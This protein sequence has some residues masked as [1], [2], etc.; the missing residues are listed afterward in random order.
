MAVDQIRDAVNKLSET[1]AGAPGGAG[2]DTTATATLRDGLAF[3]VSGPRGKVQT[4]M[5]AAIGGAAAG[6]PPAWLLRAALASCT[7]SVI[8]MRAASLGVKLDTLEVS[9]DSE[10]NI[11]GMLG[12]DEKISAGLGALRMQ[13]RIGAANADAVQ[14]REIVRWGDAHSPIACTLRAGGGSRLDVEVV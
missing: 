9:V 2:K 5:P 3:E 8:A 13:V 4:D 6:L 14:L 11:R 7:A 1:L 10:S 12:L